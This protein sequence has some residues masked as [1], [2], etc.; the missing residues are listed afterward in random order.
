MGQGKILVVSLSIYSKY[1]EGI[2][3]Y[4]V[5]AGKLSSGKQISQR[6]SKPDT[7]GNLTLVQLVTNLYY[8]L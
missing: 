2:T 1:R 5:V 7:S 3:T 8:G 6:G 4:I